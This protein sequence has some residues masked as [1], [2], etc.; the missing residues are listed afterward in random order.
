MKAKIILLNLIILSF[1]CSE[2]KVDPCQENFNW[3]FGNQISEKYQNVFSYSLASNYYNK[4]IAKNCDTLNL[5]FWFE[6]EVEIEDGKIAKE[7][8]DL[9][10]QD[11]SQKGINFINLEL[12][13]N[14]STNNKLFT[15]KE[16]VFFS[17]HQR[18]K[19]ENITIKKNN[20][21]EIAKINESFGEVHSDKIRNLMNLEIKL[22]SDIKEIDK[23]VL[24]LKEKYQSTID[25]KNIQ[26]LT[27]KINVQ[28]SITKRTSKKYRFHFCEQNGTI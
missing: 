6:E 20:Q 26:E 10:F 18:Q 11:N 27:I 5:M 23:E 8:S 2:N 24:K 28:N 1:G 14:F 13:R 15:K 22:E 12:S 4:K 16:T 9:F 25:E 17:F 3:E 21:F 19:S 7:I